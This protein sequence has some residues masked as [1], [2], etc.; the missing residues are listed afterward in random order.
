M[1]RPSMIIDDSGISQD[2][3]HGDQASSKSDQKGRTEGGGRFLQ[4]GGIDQAG[5]DA[6]R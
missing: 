6:Q 1:K 5:E 2:D 3:G 4:V